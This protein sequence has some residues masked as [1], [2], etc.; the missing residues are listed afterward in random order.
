MIIN[1]H[2][3]YFYEP[4]LVNNYLTFRSITGND[5]S[6]QIGYGETPD[7][8]WDGTVFYSTD[9]ENWTAWDGTTIRSVGGYLYFRGE[10]NTVFTGSG[11]MSLGSAVA[12]TLKNW[13]YSSI[14][15]SGNMESLLDWKLV[16]I[17]QHPEMGQYAFAYF[18]SGIRSYLASA[19]EFL[20]PVTTRG[21]YTYCFQDCRN[22]IDSPSVLPATIV[23]NE[24]YS[25]MF[26][27]CSSLQTPP[28]MNITSVGTN[29]CGWMF[30][31]CTSLMTAP[32]LAAMTLG[33]GAYKYMFYNCSSLTAAPA[34]PATTL[35]SSVYLGMFALSGITA[36]P[37]L[38]A[39]TLESQ[40]YSNMFSACDNLTKAAVL[41]PANGVWQA[42]SNM[43]AGC[44]SLSITTTGT[45]R[46]YT[47][48]ADD[49]SGNNTIFSDVSGI[50]LTVPSQ[51]YYN[52]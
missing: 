48:E 22:L 21:C 15:C 7:P 19:P 46:V 45:R 28:R 4:E 1:S 23:A 47:G 37:D 40:C 9:T 52:D 18:F 49:G 6:M 36:A 42:Y 39:T 5:F 29:G 2:W 24:A 13:D 44:M 32:V 27:G 33:S 41:P 30:Y 10:N 31:S 3:Q 14:L 16:G 17:G 43:Y 38:P 8:Q 11:A 12:L 34:L 25:S 35:A 50:T 20:S 26:T 51:D